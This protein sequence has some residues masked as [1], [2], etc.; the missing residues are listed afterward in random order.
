MKEYEISY[1]DKN[2]G[3][4]KL[5]K[6]N[7]NKDIKN[8]FIVN[9]YNSDYKILDH[10]IDLQQYEL[11]YVIN[12]VDDL[13]DIVS[14]FVYKNNDIFDNVEKIKKYN[15]IKTIKKNTIIKIVVPEIYLNNLSISK[16]NIDKGSLFKS[17]LYFVKKV[18]ENNKLDDIK[19][20]L[21]S[22]INSYKQYKNNNEYD[23]LT[24][25]EKKNNIDKYINKT[26]ELIELIEKDTKYRYGKDYIVPIKINR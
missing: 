16:N 24:E 4:V 23:F 6:D 12:D 2:I 10:K 3:K 18:S 14:K 8:S 21:D 26:N 5:F 7:L 11:E 22:L 19:N 25:E 9:N 1:N 13:Y 17:K 15:D 20:K